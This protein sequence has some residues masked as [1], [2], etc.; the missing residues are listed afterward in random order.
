MD[1]EIPI[2]HLVTYISCMHHITASSE[3][4]RILILGR[5]TIYI[6]TYL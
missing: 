4:H 6:Y 2:D 5:G 1:P 3:I